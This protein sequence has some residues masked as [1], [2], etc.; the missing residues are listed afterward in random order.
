MPKVVTVNSSGEFEEAEFTAGF[1]PDLISTDLLIPIN[2]QLVLVNE[3]IIT[4]TLD[5]QGTL[6]VL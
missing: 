6:G 5:I 3:I 2:T 4:A 1:P